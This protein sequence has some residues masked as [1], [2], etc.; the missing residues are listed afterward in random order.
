MYE[1]FAVPGTDTEDGQATFM[2]YR[3]A[4]NPGEIV[5]FVAGQRA[6]SE[7]LEARKAGKSFDQAIDAISDKKIA[8][9]LRRDDG[10]PIDPRDLYPALYGREVDAVV[11][12]RVPQRLEP[13]R[14]IH[15]ER[16]QLGLAVA[17]PGWLSSCGTRPQRSWPWSPTLRDRQRVRRPGSVVCHAPSSLPGCPARGLD[18]T[19]CC[20][21]AAHRHRFAGS[22]H[23]YRNEI[24]SRC[25]TRAAR[26]R[27]T[28]HRLR[29]L[30]LTSDV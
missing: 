15:G 29:D 11:N 14:G 7:L 24:R 30:P 28:A 23:R 10:T 6:M 19:A 4:L 26:W 16:D 22:V 20:G 5:S 9:R 27:R 13:A 21:R 25:R 17:D 2:Y 12:G 8:R 1:W 18:A 3:I